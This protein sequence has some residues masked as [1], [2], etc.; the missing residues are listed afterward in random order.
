MSQYRLNWKFLLGFLAAVAA[1]GV[2]LQV[3]YKRQVGRQAGTLLESAN[4]AEQKE[5]AKAAAYFRRYLAFRPQD[6][7][8]RGR[9]GLLLARL[10]RQHSQL[11]QAYFVLDETLRGA[12]DREDVRRK[13]VDLALQLG[14]DLL[15][16]VERHLK[17]LV[18]AHPE[19]AGL[20]VTYAEYY[21]ARESYPDAAEQFRL[22]TERRPDLY[23]AHVRRARVLR[24]KLDREKDGDEVVQAMLARPEAR[25][26]F[27][28]RLAAAAY[29]ETAPGGLKEQHQKYHAAEVGE[30]LKLAPDELDVVLAVADLQ[31]GAAARAALQGQGEER[32]K[33]L[34][35]ARAT[36]RRG[37]GR[38]APALQKVSPEEAAGLGEEAQATRAA[39]GKLFLQL[40]AAE[41]A[42]GD[43]DAAEKTAREGAEALP[44]SAALLAALADAHIRQGRFDDA[45]GE[46]TRLEAAGF[47]APVVQYHRGR[48]LAGRGQALPAA[49]ALEAVLTQSGLP[50]EL[51]PPA[52]LLLG[53]C[54]E[55]IGELDRRYA[56]YKRA[57]EGDPRDPTWL[58]ANVRLAATLLETG[59]EGEAA[60]VYGDLIRRGAAGANVPLAR[61]RLTQTLRKPPAQ[62]DWEPVEHALRAAPQ[63]DVETKLARAELEFARGNPGQA[64]AGL[65]AAA[66]DHPDVV[67][68]QLGLAL[69]EAQLKHPDRARE[70]LDA[71]RTRFGPTADVQLAEA[72][73][74]A[75]TPG[76]DAGPRLARLAEGVERL[77]RRDARR[78]LKGLAEHAAAAG[79]GDTAAALRERIL[80]LVPEDL[81]G[82]LARFEEALA[83]KDEPAAVAA[84]RRVEAV[85]GPDGAN[86]RVGQALL[87]IAKAQQGD[88]SGLARAADLLTQVEKQRPWWHRVA[89]AQGRVFE[90]A[91]EKARAAGRYKDAVVAGERRPEVV[92]RLLL[93]YAELEMARDADEVLN[94]VADTAE[95]A[96]GY[97]FLMVDLALRAGNV[98]RALGIARTIPDTETDP[99]KLLLLARVRLVA[100][101][102]AARV[103]APLRRAVE[104]AGDRPEAWVAL[105][106]LLATTDRKAEA[107]AE[108]ERARA[109][110]G[111]REKLALAQ[112]YE[113]VGRAERARPL[114]EAAARERPDNLRTLR[115]VMGFHLR[116]REAEQD[117]F[118]KAEQVCLQILK[119]RDL[120]ADDR[121]DALT[122]LAR[123]RR[124]PQGYQTAR[125]QLEAI[126]VLERGVPTRLTGRET[127]SV[128]RARA[129]YLAQAPSA[130]L[131]REA[132]AT[133]EE[134]D[135]RQPLRPEDKFLL[136]QVLVSV[137]QW[138]AARPRL[139]ALTEDR[140]PN[141]VYAAY[142]GLRVLLLDD[143]P[144]TPEARRCLKL[145]EEAQPAASATIELKARLLDAEGNTAGAVEVVKEHA[146]RDT[147][148]AAFGGLLLERLSAA[149]EAE[150]LFRS[151]AADPKQVGGTVQLAGF[152]GRQGRTED[153]LAVLADRLDTL[154]PPVPAAVGAEI[155]YHAPRAPAA[156][157]RQVEGWVQRAAGKGLTE[158]DALTLRAVLKVAEG[159][160]EGAIR[161]YEEAAGKGQPDP[162]TMN[163]L[164][165]LLALR[166]GRPA[167]GLAWV[168]KAKDAA[169]PLPG[170]LDTEAVIRT[171]NGEPQK[172]V[173]LLVDATRE[174]P[175]PAAF[176][177]LAE[178]YRATGD[179]AA[180]AA[181]LRQ[182]VRWKIRPID[183][184]P[185][186]RP[187]LEQALRT[188]R[189]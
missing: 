4:A 174:S 166:G 106:R 165:Y 78:L 168:Q 156:A 51:V 68:P 140:D 14:T 116:S 122:I 97:E 15:P 103:E 22:A 117:D 69:A 180:A 152:L 7:D 184:P 50:A 169:G 26:A 44:E 40:A 132:V 76:P 31:F 96:R 170:I 160:Y 164:G 73:L 176:Y 133:L 54:Y 123:L 104:V 183:V 62:R 95:V 125:Q 60:R 2:L 105:V 85:D 135:K 43:P 55:D 46:L 37:L 129:H 82:H 70:L 189:V 88:R 71:A 187:R 157:I 90:L 72:R 108:A 47:P 154:P 188:G 83:R 16:D 86:A 84:L 177:H 98:T 61:L 58:T 65:Q 19:D 139:K 150:K 111:D 171:A 163:N 57:T 21:L 79:A 124:D 182:A 48:V 33:A 153:G 52:A 74:V 49:R 5:P 27:R 138:P 45:D 25:G 17:V 178:A 89:L 12:P 38:H 131:R 41:T 167:D 158:A 115:E 134:I 159:Q 66:K 119:I 81:G 39:V 64:V 8:A 23:P 13:A 113:A 112:C 80:G 110:L 120:P 92:Q 146:A 100:R 53:S 10:A 63:K 101:E 75:M 24:E 181:A 93:L 126:G 11:L 145:L 20:R 32:A 128:L 141:P 147:A 162:L 151:A 67:Q 34:G 121:Q 175:D 149:G 6:H 109:R 94:L 185:L 148:R 42:A 173:E 59:Q 1:A 56:A 186:E 172:A 155:L 143:R 91:G 127:L 144:S 77:P 136:A 36:L 137:G 114:Y 142:Y 179:A 9:L 87:L 35:E 18:A 3:M 161:L 30:A 107:E 130:A 28:A 102:P 99:A 118:K 29:W